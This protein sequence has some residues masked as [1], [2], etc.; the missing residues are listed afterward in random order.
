MKPKIVYFTALIALLSIAACK[1]REDPITTTDTAGK[2]GNATLKITPKHHSRYID[3]CTVYIK[4]NTLDLPA[5]DFS[6]SKYDDNAVCIK[7]NDSAGSAVAT[8]S[9]LKKGKY[10]IYGV[11]W[12]KNGP[13][14]VAGGI[15]VTITDE[16]TYN[17]TL[18]VTE[19]D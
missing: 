7:M 9:S 19:G 4:Y 8:L 15:P 16:I 10:F 3:S 12:D 6:P 14:G 1:K 13:Y 18:P 2:G 17:V 5:G 11:G